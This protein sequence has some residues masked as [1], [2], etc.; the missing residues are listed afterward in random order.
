[1]A[2]AFT[3]KR[4]EKFVLEHRQKTGALA[5]IQDI[6]KVGFSENDITFAKKK[7]ILEELYVTLTNGVIVKGYKVKTDL[8]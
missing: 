6:T 1:M 2:D 8:F 7:K 4:L 3:L 5:T